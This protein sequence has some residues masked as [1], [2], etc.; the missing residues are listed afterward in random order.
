MNA[1]TALGGVRVL[2][3][4]HY[5]AGPYCTKLFAD[6]GADVIKVERPDGGDPARRIGPFLHDEPGLERSGLFLHL[7]TNK[8][9]ITLNLKSETGRK[10]VLDLARDCDILVENFAPDLL[11]SVGL[12]YEAFEGVNPRI[13]MTSLSNFGQT[14]PYRNYKMSEITA[15]ALGGTMQNTGLADREPLKLGLTVEQ[16]FAGMVSA[17]ATMGAYIERLN[18]GSGQHV[19]LSIMEI[20]V[21]N[22]DR[23]VQG[24]MMYRYIGPGERARAGGPGAGRNILPTGVYPTADGYVQ[25]FSLQ[26]HWDRICR[27]I[28]REDL[29]DDPYFTDPKNFTG[30]PD[31][32]AEFDAI[33]LEWL[34]VRTKRE[35]MERS[36]ECGYPCGAINSMDDVFSDPHLASR[37]F[38]AQIDHPA[39]GVL[40]YPGAPYKMT[41]TPW[42]AGR[43]PL[44]GEHTFS[45]LQEQLG[46]SAEDVARLKEQGAV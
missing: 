38:F 30:N 29:I 34:L 13:V 2:D 36:Q 17:T 45:I 26:P 28:G 22:Q 25:F 32:K 21:G 6:A 40:T 14:G 35:V 20:M 8:R 24:H 3:L 10:I 33:L 39:T 41:E 7:N 46:Y 4:T 23:A 9:S 19:D 12:T 31:V 27:M 11:P 5:I 1:P 18:S 43:A 37:G 44:L 42:R 16:F 15:Y